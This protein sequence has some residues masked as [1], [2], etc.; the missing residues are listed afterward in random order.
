MFFFKRRKK[1]HSY[2]KNLPTKKGLIKISGCE[3]ASRSGDVIFIHGLGGNAWSTWHPKE[4]YDDNFWLTWLGTDLLDIGIWSFGYAAEAFEWKGATM[5]LFDQASNLL[6]WLENRDI[7]QRPLIFVTHSLGGLVVKAMLRTAQTF[8]KQS[9]IEQTKGIVFLATPHT[10]SHLAQLID[11]I[12]ILARSTVSVEELKAH[13]PQLR[14]LNEWYRENV[15]YLGIQTKV[16]YE[17][18]PIQGILVVDQDSANPGIEGVKPVAIADNHICICKPNSQEN[19]IYIGV[20]KF[21]QEYLRVP[22]SFS[23]N[24]TTEGQITGS[25]DMDLEEIK[26][27]NGE[28]SGILT[29][30]HYS[31]DSKGRKVNILGESGI[32]SLLGRGQGDVAKVTLYD[33]YGR[34]VAESEL[35]LENN[36]VVWR[37]IRGSSEF[38]NIA[39]LGSAE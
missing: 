14:E 9:L 21:I 20:K 5:S 27:E 7:G 26:V 2:D 19:E 12:G 35:R 18:K 15:R 23:G 13:A 36:N 1:P 24:W 28:L 30:T 39:Y 17:T 4:L 6:D 22:L 3:N 8:R 33:T 16:Y 31:T 10:G 25:H 38:P 37:L 34:S 29:C 32:L 11:N